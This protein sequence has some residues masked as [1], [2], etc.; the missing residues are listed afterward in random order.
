MVT[1]SAGERQRLLDRGRQI[2][3]AAKRQ[4]DE[5]FRSVDVIMMPTVPVVAPK[6]SEESS[7]WQLPDESFWEMLAR[8]TRIFNF[9]GFPGISIPCGFTND[10]LPVGLQIAGR[11]FEEATILRVAYAYERATHWH[12]QRPP[13]LE[14]SDSRALGQP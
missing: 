6:I 11:P 3:Q 4:Y 13:M 5:V 10:R 9:T 2:S 12:E 1:R 7:P 8:H 14:S